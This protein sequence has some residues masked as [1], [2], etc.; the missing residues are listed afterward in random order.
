MLNLLRAKVQKKVNLIYDENQDISMLPLISLHNHTTFS[1]GKNFPEQLIEQAIENKLKAVAITD[2]FE[3]FTGFFKFKSN[4]Y[5]YFKIIE[6]LKEKY[7]NKIKIYS[8]LEIDFKIFDE[9]DFPFE[10]IKQIDLI[11]C[12]RIFSFED[13]QKLV[14]LRKEFTFKVGLAHPSFD[15]FE[16]LNKLV[17]ILEKNKIFVE[18]NPSCYKYF[19]PQ[20]RPD[21]PEHPLL[22]E[23]QEDFFKLIKNKNIELTI[24]TDSHRK[25]DLMENID[26]AYQFIK[27]LKLEENLIKI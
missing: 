25:N 16:N 3:Y 5:L 10:Y 6:R 4:I 14:K 7:S 15:K 19:S 9:A 12:E 22:F 11:L 2:H 13:L 1:D 23:T 18:L 20:D 24:G 27:K 26:N 8:G 17:N 21:L